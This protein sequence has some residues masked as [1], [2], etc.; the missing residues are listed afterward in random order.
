MHSDAPLSLRASGPPSPYAPPM[1]PPPSPT[2]SA[3]GA[4]ELTPLPFNLVPPQHW[5]TNCMICASQIA[6]VGVAGVGEHHQVASWITTGGLIRG[7]LCHWCTSMAGGE[8][9]V[10]R[11][12]G[13]REAGEGVTHLVDE[14]TIRE[15]DRAPTEVE[16]MHCFRA[17][18]H[19]HETSSVRMYCAELEGWVG[20]R[21]FPEPRTPRGESP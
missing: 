9:L 17:P 18:L 10:T 12:L 8:N 5:G 7:V 11:I 20:G 2:P 4:E 16:C 3:P 15:A 14:M 21:L 1:S 6:W 19:V 13:T